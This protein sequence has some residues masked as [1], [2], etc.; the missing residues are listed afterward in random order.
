MEG[1]KEDTSLTIAVRHKIAKLVG[2]PAIADD[3]M[4]IAQVLGSN[5]IVRTKKL[6]QSKY[7]AERFEQ[8]SYLQPGG[9]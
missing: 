6:N 9:A 1:D 4:A 8:Q 5:F 7:D 3:N 2:K